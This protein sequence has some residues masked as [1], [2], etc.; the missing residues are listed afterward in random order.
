MNTKEQYVPLLKLYEKMA[1]R[2]WYTL[3]EEK[4]LKNATAGWHGFPACFGTI[5]GSP[6][7]TSGTYPATTGIDL[8][9]TYASPA[10]FNYNG[11]GQSFAVTCLDRV[12]QIVNKATHGDSQDGPNVPNVAF[13]RRTD[14]NTMKSVIY[15]QH[16]LINTNTDMLK[17]GFNNFEYNGLRFY[18]SDEMETQAL[19]RAYIL[20]TRHL[21]VAHAGSKLMVSETANSITGQVGV[22]AMSFHKGQCYNSNTKKHGIIDNTES[23]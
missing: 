13:V 4:L 9:K 17:F 14:W 6:G 16:R 1:A 2:R 12:D 10:I 21:G 11:S 3:F 8:S 7:T 23:S 19:K 5:A 22:I 18:W 15:D 20:N